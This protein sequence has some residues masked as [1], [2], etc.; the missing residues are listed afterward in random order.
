[1][2]LLY[3]IA[4]NALQQQRKVIDVPGLQDLVVT[5]GR[6]VVNRR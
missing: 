6:M 4:A 3:L 2:F 1:M 5:V